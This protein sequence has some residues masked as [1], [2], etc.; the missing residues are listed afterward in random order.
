VPTISVIIPTYNAEGTILETIES[1]Q[2]QTF[3]DFEI[4]VINDGSTDQTVELVNSIADERLRIFSYENGGVSVARNRGLS[5]ATGEF[6]AF[7]DADDLW[8]PDK[9]ELQLAAL[10][11]HPEAG[12]AYSW[13]SYFMNGQ[14]GALFPGKSVFFEGNVYTK[15]L[16]ENFLANGSNP[17]VYQKAIES[18]GEFDPVLTIG[19]DWEFYLRLAARWSFVVVPKHQIFYRQSSGSAT[20]KIE[21]IERQMLVMFE[22][23]FQTAPPEYQY[24]KNQSLAWLYEYCT[25]QH[26]KNVTDLSGVNKAGLKLWKA[27]CL[28]PQILLGDYAQRLTRRLIKKWILEARSVASK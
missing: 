26:L 8:S 1:V 28:H 25:Q 21:E 13:T 18:V 17:L 20:S 24:L 5:Q 2:K 16:V 10:R 27:I 7:L 11:R 15:L 14:E 3:D 9:L 6:I 19:E 23:A 22:K 12:V 4:I